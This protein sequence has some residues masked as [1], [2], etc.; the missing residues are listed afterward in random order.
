MKR[1]LPLLIATTLAACAQM[2]HHRHAAEQASSESQQTMKPTHTVNSKYSFDDTVNRLE[3]TMRA[4]GMTI[5]TIIDHQAAA[6]KNGLQMQPAKVIIF[7]APKAGTPLMIKDP[8]FALRLPM[9]VLITETD[10]VVKVVYNDTRAFIGGSNI[11][12]SDVENSLANAEKLILHTVT[13]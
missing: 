4:K 9:R 11:Q 3:S 12:F 13:E 5:F 7:G 6:R 1:L 8:E 10:G 2:P